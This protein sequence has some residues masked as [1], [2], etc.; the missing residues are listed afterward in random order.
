MVRGR[1]SRSAGTPPSCHPC[2]AVRA[3][4]ASGKEGFPGIPRQRRDKVVVFALSR[5]C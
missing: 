3:P 4:A 2:P 5:F 1:G